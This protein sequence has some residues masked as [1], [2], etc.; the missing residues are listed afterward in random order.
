MLTLRRNILAAALSLIAAGNLLGAPAPD[1]PQTAGR[2]RIGPLFERRTEGGQ[3]TFLALRPFFSWEHDPR[4]DQRDLDVAWP[5]TTFGRRGETVRN[6]IVTV[7]YNDQNR[8]DPQSSWSLSIP[9]IFQ[10]GSTRGD[11][12]WALFPIYGKMPNFLIVNNLRFTLFPL[13][14]SYDVGGKT[15]VRRSYY[16]WPIFSLKDDPDNP[17]WSLWPLY[18]TKKETDADSRYT[19]WPIWT[20][21]TY[22]DQ[23][24][25][26]NGHAWMLFPLMARVDTDTEQSWSIIPPFFTR[27][28]TDR[29]ATLLRCPWP[30][31]HYTDE[32]ENT[33]R[34]WRI[35]GITERGTR[36]GWW[37]LHP[38]IVSTHQKTDRLENTRNRFWP[39]YVFEENLSRDNGRP[40]VKERYFRLW[41]LYSRWYTKEAGERLRLLELMPIRDAAPVERNLTPFWTLYE[42]TRIAG[43]K[44][45]RHDLLWGLIQWT[46][47]TDDLGDEP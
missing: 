3:T 17:R 33:W 22:H 31:E 2:F 44:T 24:R 10:K 45:N 34:L 32:N 38:I 1:P 8:S 42:R 16:L 20:E 11:D 23:Q 30:L 18:G 4:R 43:T 41:P 15:P 5:L 21:K 29:G 47:E 37:I 7:F 46:T 9:P 35:A 40:E 25:T 13:Y 12:Y 19:L 6:R 26:K 14:L 39:L 28:V 36:E 27:T